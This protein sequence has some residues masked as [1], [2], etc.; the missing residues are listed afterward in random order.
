MYLEALDSFSFYLNMYLISLFI[1]NDILK[2]AL[3]FDRHVNIW[4]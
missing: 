1:L 3:M 4:E 2:M